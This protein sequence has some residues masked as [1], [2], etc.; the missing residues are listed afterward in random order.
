MTPILTSNNKLVI[1]WLIRI[2]TRT[3]SG[4]ELSF[5]TSLAKVGCYSCCYLLSSIAKLRCFAASFGAVHRDSTISVVGFE[6]Q[7]NRKWVS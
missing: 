7:L 6:W 2:L 3:Y 5:G 1:I 4:Y